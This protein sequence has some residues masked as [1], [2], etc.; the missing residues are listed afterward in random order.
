MANVTAAMVKDLRE[1]TGAGMMDCK[2]ALTENNGDIEAAVDWLRQKGL[3]S[4]AK[5]S[6][7]VAAEGLVGIATSGTAGVVAEVNSETDFV[8]RN[9]DFQA[10]VKTVTELGLANDGD[11]P[12]VLDSGYPGSERKVAEQLTHNIATIGENMAIRRMHGVS[13]KNG[14]VVSYLHNKITS[15]LGKIGVLIGLESDAPADVLEGLG[16]QLA[17]HVA[18]T[19]PKSLDVD[20]LDAGIIEREKNVLVEQAR[21]SGKP[22]EIIQK[23]IEGRMR[24]FYEEVVLLQQTS[25]VDG[26]TK[27]GDMIANAGKD[28]G[29]D[30]KLVS[31]IRFELGEGI[32]KKEDDFAAEVKQAAGV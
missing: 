18:A 1:K 22:E 2:T 25:V 19:N 4:A 16:R 24:K 32:E 28:A 30:I 3:S 17:M 23:M 8:S 7:R 12:A 13:V 20:D 10:F 26:E 31:F 14:L 9:E 5:K 21:E 29:K 15:E 6:G 11:L 27:I